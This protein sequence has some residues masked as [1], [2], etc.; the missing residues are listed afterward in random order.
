M[1]EHSSCLDYWSAWS[2][3][4]THSLPSHAQHLSRGQLITRAIWEL[5]YM[6]CLQCGICSFCFFCISV[7]FTSWVSRKS[8]QCVPAAIILCNL[9]AEKAPG[10]LRPVG[11]VPRNV[12]QVSRLSHTVVLW[13]EKA[14]SL[15]Y[16]TQRRLT[17]LWEA[18][19]FVLCQ[20]ILHREGSWVSDEHLSVV[21]LFFFLIT[22]TSAT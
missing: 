3:L 19:D 21:F 8:C 9:E 20:W 18:A 4:L 2:V 13:Q 22:A 14:R 17:E 6:C 5:W 10:K 1:P 7:D 11:W 12:L 15:P 16:E